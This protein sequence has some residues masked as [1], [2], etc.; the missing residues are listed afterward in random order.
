M[1]APAPGT[2]PWGRPRCRRSRGAHGKN[3]RT[4]G[5]G[6]KNAPG[7]RSG[8]SVSRSGCGVRPGFGRPAESVPVAAPRCRECSQG[9]GTE[10]AGSDDSDADTSV[11]LPPPSRH[12]RH[13]ASIIPA[14]P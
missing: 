11:I 4:E 12:L 2:S 14:P 8:G 10:A 13:P 3:S 9:S 1:A 6:D 7:Q 5:V